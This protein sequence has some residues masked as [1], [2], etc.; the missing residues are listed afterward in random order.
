M[1]ALTWHGKRDV[2]VDRV[3]DPRI[4]APTDVIVQVTATAICG[5]DLHL[6]NGYIP[7]LE[8]GDILGH[9]TLGRVVEVGPAV[10]AFAKDDRVVVPFV[11]ACGQCGY[12]QQELTAFCDHSNP[13][14][15]ISE[16]LSGYPA[17]ALF[18]YSHIYGGIPGG[19]AEYLRVPFAEVGLLKVPDELADEQ[20]L[21]LSDVFPTGYQA[22]EVCGLK[23][24]EIVAI[25]GG[26]PV[27]QF[28]LRS[29]YMLGAAR[30]IVI[31]RLPERL[32]MAVEGQGEVINYTR[33]EDVLDRLKE[34]TGGRGPDVCIDAVGLEAHGTGVEGLYDN[35]KQSL[36]LVTDRSSAL[37]EVI[38]CCRKGG[39]VSL[40][41]VYSGIVDKFPIGVAFSKGLTLK[42]GQTHVHR[43]MRPLLERITSRQIDPRFVVTHRLPLEEARHGYEIFAEKKERCVKVVLHP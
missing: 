17:S 16:R 39:T 7:G 27:G 4:Q 15:R 31:D 38:Q 3:A 34:M 30:V 25:W 37:R 10:R 24:G 41:G 19:Q 26:G 9:E 1:K 33:A 43:Y 22:V 42:M 36:K 20:A 13:K 35:V 21:F 28:A 8:A 5:S 11:I 14:P 12:C 29:A 2:R 40:P 6:Y 18:G 32:E 23:G